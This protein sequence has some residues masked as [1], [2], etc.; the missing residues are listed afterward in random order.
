MQ[1]I[2]N[3][4]CGSVK[5]A[6]LKLKNFGPRALTDG[7]LLRISLGA[8]DDDAIAMHLIPALDRP[9]QEAFSDLDQRCNVSSSRVKALQATFELAR[10]RIRPEGIRISAPR[11]VL[12]L[13]GHLGDRKQEHVVA[14][15]L[16]GAHEVI[17][18][19]TVS[20]GLLTSCPVHPR[21]VF[22]G[23]L[24][25]RACAVILAHNHPSGDPTPSEEDKKITQQLRDAGRILGI[26]LLDHVI[27]ATRGFYSFQQSGSL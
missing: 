25:D 16:S 9:E 13:V 8:V 5:E 1:D 3:L 20:M 19:R 18:V 4:G 14:I 12:P 7:E 17:R 24:S 26:K 21:E 6:Q 2:Y 15:S 27:F 23:P 10:R 11:D 22:V